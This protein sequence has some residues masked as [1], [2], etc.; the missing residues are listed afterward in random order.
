MASI[1]IAYNT[2]DVVS[3]KSLPPLEQGDHLT[4]DEFERRY[5]AMPE[6]RKAELLEGVVHMPSPIR[7]KQH[8]VSHAAVLTWLGAYGAGTPGVQVGANASIRLDLDNEPQ[9]D[10]TLI[11]EPACGGQARINEDDY[12]EDAPELVAEVAASTVSIDLNTKFRVY[13]RNQ[14][15]EYLVWRIQDNSVDWF[16]LRE[17]EYERLAPNNSGILQ[18]A[19]FPGLWLDPAAL[20]KL[21]SARVLDVL[22]HGLAS[23]EHASFVQRL[24]ASRSERS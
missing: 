5:A 8:A 4:R 16:V 14:V 9:P 18:S 19:V 10:A 17:S 7:W 15:R 2:P 6:L 23:A 11:I 24:H 21:D 1:R 12:V 13:R 3:S 20:V 22:R